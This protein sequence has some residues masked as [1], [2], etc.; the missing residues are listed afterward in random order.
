MTQTLTTPTSLALARDLAAATAAATYPRSDLPWAGAYGRAKRLAREAGIPVPGGCPTKPK[1]AALC[2]AIE[3]HLSKAGRAPAPAPSAALVG[4]RQPI[5]V[6][7]CL[8]G[9]AC[10]YH[11]RP[12]AE[13]SRIVRMLATG[14][15]DTIDVC[16][17]VDAG[18]PVPRPPTRADADGRLWCGG[19]DVTAAF[20][21]GGKLA[22]DAARASGATKAYLVRGSP[23]CDRDH[24]IAAR[25]LRAVGVKVIRV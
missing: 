16:P 24:G 18:L 17:E 20:V 13:H 10:R 5:L 19:Q 11:G 2:A 14:R 23:S 4:A 25:M 22:V 8:L 21:R 3:A 9:V 7:R 1:A 6:S 15:Y 12:T